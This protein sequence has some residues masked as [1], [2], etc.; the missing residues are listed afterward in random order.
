MVMDF[1][2]RARIRLPN[3]K[4]HATA[5]AIVENQIAEG[6]GPPVRRTLERLMHEGLD[7]HEAVHAIGM[8]LMCHL[9]D[10]LKVGH[11]DGDPNA[12]YF[13]ELERLT[14]EEWRRSG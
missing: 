7:R 11:V 10:L 9:N 13:A 3:A 1:H 6:D 2:R 14:A 5:H 8:K 12:P 4:V